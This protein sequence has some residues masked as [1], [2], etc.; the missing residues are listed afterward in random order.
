MSLDIQIITLL[1][2]F[3]FG[4]FFALTLKINKK[5]IYNKNKI[6]KITGTFLIMLINTLIY[7]IILKNINNAQTHPYE[8]LMI[9]FGYYIFQKVTKK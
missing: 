3:L 2:S 4:I 7:F 6:I 8:L 9:I 5:I 1:V